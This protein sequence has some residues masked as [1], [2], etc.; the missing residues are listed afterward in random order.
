MTKLVTYCLPILLLAGCNSALDYSAPL[1]IT[2][3]NEGLFA[4]GSAWTLT[5]GAD[6]SAALEIRNYPDTLTREFTL[7]GEQIAAFRTTIQAE[8]F[9]ELADEYGEHVPDGTTQSIT[10]QLGD[11][12]KTVK[13]QYLGNWARDSPAKLVEPSRAIRVFRHARKW[14]DD[15]GAA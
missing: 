15:E 9:F 14:F 4:S 12:T 8:R 6:H 13:L 5:V 1:S 3:D 11:K 7:T 2:I 10:V